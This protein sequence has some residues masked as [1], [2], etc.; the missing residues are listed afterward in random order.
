MAKM[1]MMVNAMVSSSSGKDLNEMRQLLQDLE[2]RGEQGSH[3]DRLRRHIARLE[4]RQQ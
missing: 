2:A 3:V 1:S 4:R